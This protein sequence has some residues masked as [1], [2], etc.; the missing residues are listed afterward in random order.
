M[1]RRLRFHSTA[2]RD[3]TNLAARS[4]REWGKA[5]TRRYLDEIE[6]KIQAIVENPMLGHDAGLP[7]PGLRRINAGR[8]VV[9]YM[10]D[11]RQV[12][13]VRIFHER[14]DFEA[15]LR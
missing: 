12:E 14:M 10:F 7:R 9:F 13:V 1:K 11:E 15:Q 2:Q 3:F 6:N 5:R 4:E 8:D